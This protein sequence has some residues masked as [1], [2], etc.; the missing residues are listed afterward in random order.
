MKWG[1]IAVAAALMATLNISGAAG[2]DLTIRTTFTF[3][4]ALDALTGPYEA[5]SGDKVT[6]AAQGQ[7]ADLMLLLKAQF[8]PLVKDGSVDPTSVADFGQVRVGFA[9]KAGAPAPDIS[10]PEKF[11]AVLLAAKSVGVS[12]FTSGLFV[13]NEVFPK[14]GIADAMKDKTTVVNGAIGEGVAKGQV[15]A[16]F[17]Q[18]SELLP[19]KGITV[20]GRIPEQVNRATVL[21]SGLGSQNKAPA[22]ANRFLAYMK[23]PAGLAILKKLDI[24]PVK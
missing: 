4:A 22:A 20:V 14:L 16:G 24:D 13:K 18:M 11:K 19:I 17:Q 8:E 7:P 21:A 6:V 23:S 1:W 9:V 15:E 3:Q 12:A 2:E 10:T 5:A